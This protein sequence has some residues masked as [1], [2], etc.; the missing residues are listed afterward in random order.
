[1][2]PPSKPS[3]IEKLDDIEVVYRPIVTSTTTPTTT[4]STT[5]THDP[6]ADHVNLLL[7]QYFSTQTPNVDTSDQG[8]PM[9]TYD[10]ENNSIVM[11][12]LSPDG[13]R[14]KIEQSGPEQEVGEAA[15]VPNFF[16]QPD[17]ADTAILPSM[18][19]HSSAESKMTSLDRVFEPSQKTGEAD[20]FVLDENGNR[21]VRLEEETLE[22]IS[23]AMES[24]EDQYV[25]N[26]EEGIEDIEGNTERITVGDF[27]PMVPQPN[28]DYVA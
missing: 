8:V 23:A 16:P 6:I 19:H 13:T 20:W 21:R 7:Q 11:E 12:Y 9:I 24:N 14:D 25:E 5:T 28:V 15:A 17:N 2:V 22:E 10:D 4:E 27:E 1:M 3:K 18:L 26:Q